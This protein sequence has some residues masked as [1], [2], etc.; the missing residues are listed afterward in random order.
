M[1]EDLPLPS[2]LITKEH[3]KFYYKYGFM[4]IKGV[5]P[6]KLVNEAIEGGHEAIKE[7]VKSAEK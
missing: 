4:V 1:K 7:E 6:K 2:K 5:Y 3:L